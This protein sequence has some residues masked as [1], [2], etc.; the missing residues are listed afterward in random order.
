VHST[1]P[2]TPGAMGG[3]VLTADGKALGVVVNVG[4]L[5]NAGAN[6]V[7]RLDTLMAYAAEHARLDMHL[8][9]SELL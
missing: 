5:P 8:M 3:A 1:V 6:G 9:T 2:A 4:V 7:A